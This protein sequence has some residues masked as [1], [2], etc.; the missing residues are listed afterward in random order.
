MAKCSTPGGGRSIEIVDT[1]DS[2]AQWRQ[3]QQHVE[4]YSAGRRTTVVPIDDLEQP[5]NLTQR[6]FRHDAAVERRIVAFWKPLV[7][8]YGI[9]G[10]VLVLGL[11]WM[12]RRT[13]AIWSALVLALLT[14]L[15]VHTVISRLRSLPQSWRPPFI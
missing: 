9:V 4:R 13:A 5:I 12:G 2:A 14:P 7:V 6:L 15:I 10:L 1:Q 8:A 3:H 11:G